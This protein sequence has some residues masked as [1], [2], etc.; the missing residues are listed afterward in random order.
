MPPTFAGAGT[1]DDANQTWVAAA[2]TSVA[3]VVWV[4]NSIGDFDLKQWENNGT[5]GNL[6]RHE[7]MRGTLAV[8]DAKYGGGGFPAPD[9]KLK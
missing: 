7:I 2:S 8:I 5:Q 9:P 4:G 3:T 1:T 6:L